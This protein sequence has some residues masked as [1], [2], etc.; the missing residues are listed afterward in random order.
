M[1][2]GGHLGKMIDDTYYILICCKTCNTE[3]VC[4]DKL[5]RLIGTSIPSALDYPVEGARRAWEVCRGVIELGYGNDMGRRAGG[6]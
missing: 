5:P 3:G 4:T 1:E 6:V 2:C